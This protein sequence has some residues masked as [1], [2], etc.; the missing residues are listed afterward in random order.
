[1]KA[2]VIHPPTIW[3]LD[4]DLNRYGSYY[5]LC[6][7]FFNGSGNIRPS[8]DFYENRYADVVSKGELC[9]IA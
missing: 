3:L 7:L 9:L 5:Q 8:N 6:H 4:V 2:P 1:M